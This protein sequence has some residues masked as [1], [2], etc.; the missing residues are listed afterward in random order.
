[1]KLL[2]VDTSGPVCGVAILTEDGIRH[3][4][5]VMN[6]KTHSVNLLPMIDNAF[7]STGLTIQNMDRLAVVVG[8]GS[9]T[10]VRLGVSTVKGL[11]HGAGKP[12]VAVNALEAM[13]ALALYSVGRELA[14]WEKAWTL[15]N[16]LFGL[17]TLAMLTALLGLPFLYRASQYKMLELEQATYA[18]IGRPL[19]MRFLLLLAGETILLGV[20]V[21]NV[22]AAV[23]WSIGQL[24]A[25][26]TVPFLTANNELL[27]LLRWVRP[28]WMMTGAVP[29]FAGQMCLLRFVQLSELPK[30]LPLAA[31]VLVL[32]M[33]LQC[34]RLA[35]RSEYIAE[36]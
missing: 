34:I 10:G 18:G 27:L 2:A 35:A 36:A 14:L 11:A 15:R 30:G 16:A 7:Q 13:A 25:V 4:C 12:C 21:L 20:L 5:A 32:C 1:M 9:F 19:V 26:L 8:P 22:R 23:P 3:E 24:L 28:E 33:V 6:H 31:G 29:L 17:S